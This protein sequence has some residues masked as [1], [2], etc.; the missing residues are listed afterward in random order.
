MALLNTPRTY[1]AV[2][3]LLH[4]LVVVLFVTQYAAAFLMT[5][6]ARDERVLGLSQGTLYNWHKSIGLL[7]L[8]VALVRY[9]WRRATPLPDWAPTLA[10]FER[11]VAHAVERALYGAMFLMPV[12]GFLFVMAG[13]YGVQLFGVW[14]LPNFVGESRTLAW[15]AELLHTLAS[16]AIV[17]AL[18]L[19]LGLVAKHQLVD[20]DRLLSRMLPFGRP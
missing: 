6:I 18:T 4:W 9:L 15:L 7:A 20:R 3:R 17:A 12:S 10:P 13:G 5:S 16:Y 8:A 19:H 1:G 14:P 11:R 2:S